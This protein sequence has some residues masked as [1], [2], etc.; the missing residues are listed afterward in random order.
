MR[1]GV[2]LPQLGPE[3]S[4]AV[5]R[6]F[7]MAAEAAGLHA[8]WVVDRML[9][10]LGDVELPLDMGAVMPPS[11]GRVYSPLETLVHV[12]AF[13]DRIGLG[14]SVIDALFHNPAALGRRLA[15][16]DHLCDGRLRVAL[17]QG[18]APEE[19]VA[20]HVPISRRGTGFDEFVEALRAV[21]GPDP[22]AYE[23]RF[24]RIPRGE[25]S[26]KPV[27]RP[28]LPLMMGAATAAGAR[29]AGRLGM[30]LNPI[31]Y[32]WAAL[33]EQLCEHRR[34]ASEAGHDV[35]DLP[36]V[37]RGMLQTERSQFRT[38]DAP[39]SGTPDE[40]A[41]DIEVLRS[42][43]VQEIALD[44]IT[45]GHYV[46]DQLAMLGELSAL[47][48]RPLDSPAAQLDTQPAGG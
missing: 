19:F 23:G 21:W 43:G 18:Y 25:I 30:G 29:R 45:G 26:P 12:G 11:Y 20:A 1:V 10:P 37:V 7:A 2:S 33:E 13:T 44:L 27:Q 35:E 14:T 4:P 46:R 3:A 47:Q 16:V 6:E 39:L 5:L 41:D 31:A 38:D 28:T 48:D 24:Y 42:W 34:A 22:V 40:I 9:R 8:L 17:G 32:T 36:V 15:T